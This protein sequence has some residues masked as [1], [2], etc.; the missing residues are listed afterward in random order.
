M[1][2]TIHFQFAERLARSAAKPDVMGTAIGPVQTRDTTAR[3]AAGTSIWALVAG[4]PAGAWAVKVG[5]T[6]NSAT[7]TFYVMVG[8]CTGPGTTTG[9]QLWRYRGGVWTEIDTTSAQTGGVGV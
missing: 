5:A 9:D 3:A 7:P 2:V 1:G 8:G 4:A 6:P